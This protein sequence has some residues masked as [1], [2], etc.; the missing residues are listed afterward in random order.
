MLPAVKPIKGWNYTK[1]SP[2]NRK[3]LSVNIYCKK[4][5]T[6]KQT[7]QVYTICKNVEIIGSEQVFECKHDDKLQVDS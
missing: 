2:F 4:G 6:A 3:S 7:E 5:L 1:S